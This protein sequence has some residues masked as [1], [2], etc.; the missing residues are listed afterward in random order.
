MLE[1]MGSV[2]RLG[3]DYTL[4]RRPP[5]PAFV[6]YSMKSGGKAW[7]DYHGMHAVAADVT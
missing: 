5:C 6:T 3:L 2:G 1:I 7:K 4:V